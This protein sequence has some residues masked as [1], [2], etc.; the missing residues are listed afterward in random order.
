MNK[1][2]VLSRAEMALEKGGEAFTLTAIMAILAIALVA[3][4]CYRFFTSS[5]GSMSLPGGF[6]F[7]WE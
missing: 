2:H 7:E 6:K 3:V 5:E 1:L 4:V